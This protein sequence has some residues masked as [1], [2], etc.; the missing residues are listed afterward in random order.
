[1]RHR[2]RGR[3]RRTSW[4]ARLLLL[5]AAALGCAVLFTVYVRPII[6]LH[7]ANLVQF[8]A[9]RA[10]N[11]AV[12][13]KIYQNRAQYE[14]LVVL[15]RDNDSRVTALKTDA[16]SINRIKTEIVNTLYD[17]VNGLE[18]TSLD[19][20]A[21]T[22]LAPD[23]LGGMGP[24]MHVGMSGLG[25]AS[26]EF[27]SAFTQA[28]INQTR[29]NIILEVRADVDVMTA[30]G[31]CT[32]TVTSRFNVTDTV[33]VGTVPEQYTYI[34]DTEQSLLGKINDYAEPA[35]KIPKTSK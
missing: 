2:R 1:M 18:C 30:F 4:R 16:I 12:Q 29:H 11:D 22:V 15:E 9:T 19:I 26:A 21:G 14:E 33:I 27:I 6:L 5:F 24:K 23:Y 7:A 20:P 28:G 3:P 31:R 17:A 25:F 34:D 32:T 35:P 10:I 8:T 13:D